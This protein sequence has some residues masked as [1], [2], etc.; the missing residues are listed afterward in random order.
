MICSLAVVRSMPSAIR[1]D[2]YF[3]TASTNADL[4]QSTVFTLQSVLLCLCLGYFKHFI[5]RL[6]AG[7]HRQQ[8]TDKMRGSR[9][10]AFFNK[11]LHHIST[12]LFFVLFHS[13]RVQF[14]KSLFTLLARR[15]QAVNNILTL[16]RIQIVKDSFQCLY[17]RCRW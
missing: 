10:A 6:L 5:E 4:S 11:S 2:W 14:A 12:S 3:L 13:Q 9:F 7:I 1:L 17:F 15:H 16:M 8:A